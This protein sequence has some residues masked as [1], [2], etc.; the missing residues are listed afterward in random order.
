MNSGLFHAPNHPPP[1][2]GFTLIEVVL[3]MAVVTF[4]LVALIGMVPAAQGIMQESG[5][6]GQ[7]DRLQGT[8]RQSVKG[9]GFASAAAAVDKDRALYLYRYVGG[10]GTRPDGTLM[11]DPRGEVLLPGAA[12]RWQDDPLLAADLQ[13]LSGPL[14][15][16]K[17]VRFPAAP[18]SAEPPAALPTDAAFPVWAVIEHVPSGVAG[19]PGRF[20]AKRATVLQP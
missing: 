14:F 11:P 8:F 17:L 20:L 1:A 18:G 15:K 19:Q 16:I 9:S 5:L 7:W 12:A 4:S 13:A 10:T 2:R 6:R 3:A